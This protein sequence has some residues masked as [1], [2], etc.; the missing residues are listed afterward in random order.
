MTVAYVG[1]VHARSHIKE[2]VDDPFE[3]G[4]EELDDALN[5]LDRALEMLR[6]HCREAT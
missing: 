3:V 5:D 4:I 1:V 2:Y 6:P